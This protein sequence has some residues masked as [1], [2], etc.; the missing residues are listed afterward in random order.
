VGGKKPFTKG[1]GG[2][3]TG[4]GPILVQVLGGDVDFVRETT[5]GTVAPNL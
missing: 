1:E 2:K 4:K 5:K 3:C